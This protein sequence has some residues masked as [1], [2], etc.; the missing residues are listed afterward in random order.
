MVTRTREHAAVETGA[1]II[2]PTDTVWDSHPNVTFPAG[3]LGIA[4]WAG[5]TRDGRRM[6]KATLIYTNGLPGPADV[7]LPM[8]ACEELQSGHPGNALVA[9]VTA[10]R[11]ST[12]AP[13]SMRDAMRA[14][15]APAP[16]RPVVQPAPVAPTRP[17]R[18]VTPPRRTVSS[19]P[20]TRQTP[21]PSTAESLEN[22]LDTW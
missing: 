20:P 14:T 9:T 10:R 21:A 15:A 2:L 5:T 7:W 13:V 1:F 22:I 6:V 16:A 17:A 12:G 8:T 19:V 18:P 4:A 11:R 3:T